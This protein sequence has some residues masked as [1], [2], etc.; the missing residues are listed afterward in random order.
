M[1]KIILGLALMAGVFCACSEDKLDTYSGENYIQFKN[2]MTDSV[3]VS[4]MLLPGQQSH[5]IGLPLYLIGKPSEVER[6]Y[7][8]EVYASGVDDAP[9]AAYTLPEKFTFAANA[10]SDTLWMLKTIVWF[11]FLKNQKIS[12]WVQMVTAVQSFV[13]PI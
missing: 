8:C 9:A 10:V 6:E 7:I 4:F 2:P 1:K 12:V 3:S 5:K 11:F 13:L